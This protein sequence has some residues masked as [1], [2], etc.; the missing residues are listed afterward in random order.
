[1]VIIPNVLVISEP[2]ILVIILAIVALLALSPLF[3]GLL[4][5]DQELIDQGKL[6]LLGLAVL[7]L[8]GYLFYVNSVY[9]I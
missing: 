2:T 9:P 1:M 5:D 3:R 6:S 8:L 7:A 4:N